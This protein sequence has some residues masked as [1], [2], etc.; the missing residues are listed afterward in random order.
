VAALEGAGEPKG[1]RRAY[2]VVIKGVARAKGRP[3]SGR[4]RNGRHQTY[5]PATTKAWEET[6]GWEFVSAHGRP[7][8]E[9]YLAVEIGFYGTT[10]VADIDN[11][12]KAVLD[13]LNEIAWVDD[14]QVVELHAVKRPWVRPARTEIT[15]RPVAV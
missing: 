10:P 6:V 5:T 8:L 1:A 12:V 2:S 3:R 4:D 13:G 7:R 14:H 11:L 15:V 9:G